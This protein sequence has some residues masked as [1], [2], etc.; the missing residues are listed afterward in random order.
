MEEK[1]INA[2]KH[3]CNISVQLSMTLTVMVPLP[4][5]DLFFKTSGRVSFL[6]DTT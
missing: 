6:L 1:K 3:H 5:G 4:A 2:A